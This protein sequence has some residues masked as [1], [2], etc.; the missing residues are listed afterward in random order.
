VTLLQIILTFAAVV[1]GLVLAQ[2]VS[3]LTEYFTSTET[4][5]VREIAEAARR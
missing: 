2:I 3:R 5:P 4:K 1:I